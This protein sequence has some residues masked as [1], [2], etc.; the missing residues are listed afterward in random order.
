MRLDLGGIR[1][2]ANAER[3]DKAAGIEFPVDL[4]ICDEVRVVVADGTIDLPEQ[5]D[6][7]KLRALPTQTVRNVGDLLTHRGWRRRLTV[8]AREHGHV[9]PV[10]RH[11]SQGLDDAVHRGQHDLVAC[12]AQHQRVA[13]IVDVL[14]ST[15]EMHEFDCGAATRNARNTLFQKVFDR[16]HI[17][18]GGRLEFLDPCR[19]AQG[20]AIHDVVQ[21][22]PCCGV[23]RSDFR[24]LCNGGEALQPAHLDH[25]PVA[26]QAILAE[27]RA[28]RRG[29]G[30][31]APVEW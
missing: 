1:I 8:G 16:F 5:S 27:Y 29:S 3:L 6:L 26:D 24:H 12:I 11:R 28:Q 30:S 19:I 10:L 2:P 20:E 31:I 18:I 21:R 22:R 14:G 13:E 23:E 7:C 17:V 9:C 15:G 4:G 25:Y